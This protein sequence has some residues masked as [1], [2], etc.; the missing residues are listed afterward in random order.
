M[1]TILQI[2]DTHIVAKGPLVSN[3]LDTAS[4]LEKLIIRINQLQDKHND[5]EGIL[6]SG[7]ISDDGSLASYQRFKSIM[8]SIGLPTYVIPGNHDNRENMREAFQSDK[9]FTKTGPLNWH[10]KIGNINIIGLDTLIEG[11]G[12]G[13]LGHK[14]LEYLKETLTNLHSQPTILALHH[15][16]FET[17]IKFMDD[18]GLKNKDEFKDIISNF[19]GE[20]RVVCGHIHCMMVASLNNHVVISS[21]S[22]S[23]NFEYDT[24][25]NAPIG[26]MNGVDGFL[27]HR[28]N[29]G[30]QSIRVGPSTGAGPFPF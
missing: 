27:L 2:S 12:E 22:P 17:G 8:A 1:T 16:P 20:L 24:R 30:F 19:N 26:F 28:W 7:D 15:P 13:Y 18:I 3:V 14:S 6:V 4:T 21:P 9:I 23:S 5:I 11:K 29:N 25:P 10:K